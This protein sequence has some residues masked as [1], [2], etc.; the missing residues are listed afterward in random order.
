MRYPAILIPEILAILDKHELDK[1]KHA[2]LL[3]EHLA[4]Q[5]TLSSTV[6]EMQRR[7]ERKA[8]RELET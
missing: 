2:K 3:K 1:A 4:G 5:R 6:E 8:K 7:L